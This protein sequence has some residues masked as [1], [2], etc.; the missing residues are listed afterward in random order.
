LILKIARQLKNIKEQK[1]FTP[2]SRGLL[3]NIEE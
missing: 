1:S 2:M 3:F